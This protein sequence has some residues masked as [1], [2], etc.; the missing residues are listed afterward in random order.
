[1]VFQEV[2]TAN[3]GLAVDALDKLLNEGSLITLFLLVCGYLIYQI[4]KKDKEIN[5]L[6]NYLKELNEYIRE[7]DK[8]N[9]QTLSDV[10]R[11]LDKVLEN[12]KNTDSIVVNEIA[13]LKEV[14]KLMISKKDKGNDQ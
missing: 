5:R 7:S 14:I 8:E 12:Q 1:M 3:F 2:V 10:S 6:N 11:T 9:L 13:N 4:Q